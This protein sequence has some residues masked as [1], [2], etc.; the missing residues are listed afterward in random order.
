MKEQ[1]KIALWKRLKEEQQKEVERRL[2][3]KEEIAQK[4]N[5]KKKLTV[6]VVPT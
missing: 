2:K 6:S 4:M 1:M 3:L 5:E